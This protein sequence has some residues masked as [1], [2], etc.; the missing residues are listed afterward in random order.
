MNT[1]AEAIEWFQNAGWIALPRTWALGETILVA[2][3]KEDHQGIN[4]LRHA[5]YLYCQDGVWRIFSSGS[6]ERHF[7]QLHDAVLA[8]HEWLLEQIRNVSDGRP[9]V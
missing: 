6:A 9:C 7:E 5:V 8:I 2:A 1:H 3:S 4:M